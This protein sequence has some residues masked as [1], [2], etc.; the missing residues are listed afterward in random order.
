VIYTESGGDAFH[1]T[2]CN[3]KLEPMLREFAHLRSREIAA[4]PG[5][6]GVRVIARHHGARL[7]EPRE[8]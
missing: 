5:M 1:R 6:R 2:T 8:G 3:V 4:E 7:V